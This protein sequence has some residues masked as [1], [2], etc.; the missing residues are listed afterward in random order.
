MVNATSFI[1]A[2]NWTQMCIHSS[3]CPK[4]RN[5][6]DKLQYTHTMDCCAVIKENEVV[7]LRR[8]SS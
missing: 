1:M 6:I 4:V 8:K 5:W 7:I 2:E 3:K